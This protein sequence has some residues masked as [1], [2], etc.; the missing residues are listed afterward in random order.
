[1]VPTNRQ[2]FIIIAAVALRC[3]MVGGMGCT[4]MVLQCCVFIDKYLPPRVVVTVNCDKCCP[5]RYGVVGHVQCCVCVAVAVAGIDGCC[6]RFMLRVQLLPRR[7]RQK[8]TSSDSS[9]AGTQDG[10]TEPSYGPPC[11]VCTFFYTT[12]VFYFMLLRKTFY[13][14][15]RADIYFWRPTTCNLIPPRKRDR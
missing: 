15:V 13:N 10:G 8:E 2:Q 7:Q 6:L 9:P 4:T 14:R 5:L 12:Y 3:D 11:F 1:M